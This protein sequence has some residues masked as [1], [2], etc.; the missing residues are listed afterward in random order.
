MPTYVYTCR[1]DECVDLE[2]I[3]KMDERNDPV[4]CCE[5]CGKERTRKVEAPSVSLHGE[6]FAGGKWQSR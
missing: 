2:L 4:P 5:S 3:R 6:G 1:G